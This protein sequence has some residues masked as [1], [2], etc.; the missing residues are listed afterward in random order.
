MEKGKELPAGQVVA[1]S[2]GC[3]S[4]YS[5]NAF[6]K[7]LKPMNEAAWNQMCADCTAPPDY[8][9]EGD[10]RFDSDKAMEWLRANGY[11]EE[12]EYVELHMGSYRETPNWEDA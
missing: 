5:V 4:D 11:I 2:T 9:P 1:F 3:Y 12:I 8:Y 6:G 7:L 10:P